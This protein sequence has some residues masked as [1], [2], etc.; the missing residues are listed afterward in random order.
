VLPRRTWLTARGAGYGEDSIY[1][2]HASE[3][4]DRQHHR[5][6]CCQG[7]WPRR[8]EGV[9]ALA[10][11]N[12]V[13]PVGRCTLPPRARRRGV[14]PA[15]AMACGA[16]LGGVASGVR[17]GKW[18][19]RSAGVRGQGRPRWMSETPR[20]ALPG[21]YCFVAERLPPAAGRRRQA[22]G[23]AGSASLPSGLPGGEFA[24]VVGVACGVVAQLDDPGDVDDVVEAAV[25]GAR[26]PVADVLAA[27]GVDGGGAG[28]GREVVAVG[29]P[30]NIAGVG[31][32]P[33]GADW[34]DAVDCAP[35]KRLRAASRRSPPRSGRPGPPSGQDDHVPADLTSKTPHGCAAWWPG[36]AARGR[37]G[38]CHDYNLRSSKMWRPRLN[39]SC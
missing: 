8:F 38:Q 6:W 31:Q 19:I 1:F 26:Q 22:G 27:G 11:V 20:G 25:P 10:G 5:G 30:G 7:A 29:E 36:A 14:A 18:L 13:R 32:D 35:A 37:C 9:A 15:G 2:D 23:A 21:P 24:P 12:V 3:C 16:C 39:T 33:G 4:R 34:A 17:S 28:P